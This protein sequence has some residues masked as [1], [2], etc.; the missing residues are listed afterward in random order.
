M[1][2]FSRCDRRLVLHGL[3]A[4]AASLLVAGPARARGLGLGSLLGRASDS[5]L[6]RLAQ[7]NAFYN[8]QSIRIGLPLIGGLGGLGGGGGL[9]SGVLGAGSRFG[10]LDGL[11]RRLNDAAGAAAGAAK[12]IFRAAIDNLSLTDVPGIVSRNK[13]ATQYL[14]ESAGDELELKLRPLVDTGLEDA[15]AYSELD[16]LNAK[17]SY[18]GLAGINRDGL[19]S[20]VTKKALGGI[21]Q[22]IGNE[23]AKLRADP[24]GKAGGLLKGVLGN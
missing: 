13:G 4:A 11:T 18:L 12:P 3:G 19:G 20:H 1:P 2:Q 17:H 23:E 10:L 24:L 14:R 15:G 7:P 6:D 21:F 8:D 9:L 22:Y 16:K 5:A